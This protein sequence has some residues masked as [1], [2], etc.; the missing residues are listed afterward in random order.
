[1]QFIKG[2]RL[3]MKKKL[4]NSGILVLI[5]GFGF[6]FQYKYL[7]EF[8]SH[9]HAWA[10]SDRY[11]LSLGFLDNGLNF[12][13]PQTLVYN[14]QFPEKW[15]IPSSKTITAVDF[16]IH[17][18]IP[19]LLM[20]MLGNTS[21]WVFRMYIL[22]YSFLGL[23]FLFKFTFAITKDYIKSVFVVVFTATSPV[24]VYYQAGFLPT[25]PSLSNAIIGVYFYHRY[26]TENKN[27]DFWLS[28]LILT[29][30]ALSR[31]TFAIPIV[32]M[33]AVEFIRLL[34]KK[35]KLNLGSRLIPVGISVFSL[36]SYLLYNGYLREKYGSLFLNHILPPDNFGEVK[37]IITY[38]YENWFFHYFTRVHYVIF[39]VFIVL[40]FYFISIRKSANQKANSCLGLFI[41]T[42]LFGCFIFAYLMLR[43]FSAHDYYFLDT[44]FLPI[45]M[46]LIVI[47]SVIPRADKI[48]F[49]IVT[50][51][52]FFVITY[53]LILQPIK[54]QEKRRETGF[55]DRTEA[56]IN[57]FKNSSQF[58][59]SLGI[60]RSS[61]ILVLDAVAPNIPFI[62][63]QRKG[64]AVMKAN[65]KNME[66]ALKW[67]YDYIVIQN[68][69]FI[70]E[71]Y[72]RYPG[73]LS[74]LNKIANNGEISVCTLSKNNKQNLLDFMGL[75]NRKI[76]F[77][78]QVSFDTIPDILWQNF[79]STDN[80]AFQSKASSHLTADVIYGVSYKTRN[81]PELETNA[82][83][84]LF[85][86]YFLKEKR[87]NCEIVVSIN[88]D[89]KILYYKAANLRDLIRH[90][91]RW[92]N[93]ILLFDLPK[94]QSTD[95]EFAL[96]LWN[97]GK[98]DLYYDDFGFS[99]Y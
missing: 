3:G 34:K 33:L 97:P 91:G 35:T 55:W 42:Y 41:L 43:Q 20:K 89:G 80:F 18:Y 71:I 36:A 11:A 7:N 85:S 56:T 57:N 9:I 62:L 6:I 26:L 99:L 1:M 51:T 37:E 96:Y 14:H 52:T 81:L 48:G 46:S 23:F 63:M 82:R 5:I 38:V 22:F 27:K 19:A 66:E 78:K 10:Q 44:F 98:S 28:L 61:K 25:I 59:D 94:I 69:Y 47:L 4:Q 8:P 73:I 58:L 39:S 31:T 76:V 29:L 83:T 93:V 88:S 84:L 68:E 54:S 60:S 74:K 86:S 13:N 87:I 15:T 12:F 24:Y 90:N 50:V 70:P 49:K 40:S 45:I 17:D 53:L 79:N 64:F 2:S 30:A 77:E 67:D 65:Q 21:V 32:A 92:E 72:N 95:Y 75:S 16:P